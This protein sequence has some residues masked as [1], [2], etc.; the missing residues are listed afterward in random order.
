MATSLS[1]LKTRMERQTDKLCRF[2][3][4]VTF[5]GKCVSDKVI[6][7]G[8]TVKFGKDALPKNEYLHNRIQQVTDTAQRDIL[9][10]CKDTYEVLADE[11]HDSVQRLKYDIFQSC[12]PYEVDALRNFSQR[13]LTRSRKQY[14]KKKEKKLVKLLPQRPDIRVDTTTKK[15]KPCRRFKRKQNLALP[16]PSNSDPEQDDKIVVNLSDVTLTEP[17]KS[18]LALGPKFCPTPRSL[19]QEQ[20]EEDVHE[21]LRRLRLKELFFYP[22][23]EDVVDEAPKFYKKNYYE[24]QQGRDLS[25]D[26]YC[27]T[28]ESQVKS[29][30]PNPKS[31]RDNLSSDQ[32][33]ALRE[34]QQHVKN[35][36]LR[37]SSADKGG[38]VVVQ[39]LTD[40]VREAERQLN[41]TTYYEPVLTDPTCSVAKESNKILDDLHTQKFIDDNT[42]K[43]ARL[44]PNN[45]RPHLFHHLP[46]I[47]KNL[48]NPPGRP[49]VSGI[50]G[51]TETLSKLAD[52]WLHPLVVSLPSY[53][54]DSTHMLNVIYEWNTKYGPLPV[55]AQLVTIDVVS[56]YTNIPQQDMVEAIKDLMGC[57]PLPDCPPMNKTLNVV[58]HV[59]TNNFFNFEGQTYK[60]KSGTA[61]GTPMAPTVANIFMGRLEAKLLENSPVRIEEDV[62]KRFIDDI[63]ILWTRSQKDLDQFTTYINSIHP[64]IKFTIRNSKTSLPFLD[65]LITIEDGYLTSSL[66]VKSTDTKAYLPYNSSHPRHCVNGIPSSQFLQLRRLCSNDEDFERQCNTMANNFK[67]RSYPEW[68]IK[69]G[70]EKATETP[71]GNTLEYHPQKKAGRVPMVVTHNPRNPPLRKYLRDSLPTLHQSARMR[72]VTLE[73][74]ILG[75]RNS[76]SLRDWLMPSAPPDLPC[77]VN[78][79]CHRCSKTCAA[80]RLHLMETT[81]FSSDRTG[82]RFTIRQNLGCESTNIIYLLSCNLCRHAQ[83]V[84]ETKNTVSVRF[85]LHRSHIRHNIGTPVTEHFNLAGHSCENVRCIILEQVFVQSKEARLRREKFWMNKLKTIAPLG[86]NSLS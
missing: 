19:N 15:K 44:E 14:A 34:L 43:W 64:T 33:K 76:R 69:K 75:E 22:D 2:R 77:E 72:K 82:E 27:N 67:K 26:A 79:G 52:H 17:Q 49:I 45:V 5:L 31:L 68:A 50:R 80:C 39:N 4:H 25:L 53:I 12:S 24:P 57:H 13:C 18:V 58:N 47:H 81:G 38:A 70:R 7:K 86:L 30:V 21:G 8:M 65:I 11:A 71:R 23:V 29:H 37:I 60:Q 48:Q 42:Y 51:P 63:L 54:K 32:R 36:T 78:P 35:R 41:N 46:K 40:Y 83:Y 84:G 62:W 61:M 66:F 9:K 73:P 1:V 74:P 28:V 56:L 16:Q 59:L 85:T 6:P 55:D 10:L 20:L 3:S